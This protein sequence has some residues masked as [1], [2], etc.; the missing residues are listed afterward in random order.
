MVIKKYGYVSFE[1]S[2]DVCYFAGFSKY[3]ID[4]IVETVEDKLKI[5]NI[6]L[7]S[8]I[9]NIKGIIPCM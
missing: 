1:S 7:F 8:Y 3:I 6:L 9:N 5:S 4:S 2:R